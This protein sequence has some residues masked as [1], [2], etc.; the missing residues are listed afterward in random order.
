MLKKNT[1]KRLLAGALATVMML[2]MC[3]SW[4]L[5][6]DEDIATT[7][8][9]VDENRPVAESAP[10]EAD[11]TET[12]AV[13]TPS[14][15]EATPDKDQNTAPA[16][17]DGGA[18]GGTDSTESG[19][20]TNPT[21]PEGSGNIS[22]KND[23]VS[24]PPENAISL[25]E[26][27]ID[28][29]WPWQPKKDKIKYFVLLPNRDKPTSGASQGPDNYLPSSLSDGGVDGCDNISGY[30]GGDLTP[31]GKK[32]ADQHRTGDELTNG[33][34]KIDD[35]GFGDEYLVLPKDL[36]FFNENYWG[37]DGQYN[38]PGNPFTSLGKDFNGKDIKI[39]WYTIKSWTMATISTATLRM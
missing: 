14:E 39:V 28:L 8:P 36:G 12:P 25:Q 7:L 4:A 24:N 15:P 5:A 13:P 35:V 37:E 3:P 23:V 38:G 33:Y 10:V 9:L 30:T 34:T 18:N 27:L 11:T 2:T 32:M 20:S 19:N 6:D 31:L 21:I 26:P 16:P 1:R 17:S 22:Q 29:T